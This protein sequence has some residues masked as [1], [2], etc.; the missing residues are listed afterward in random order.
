MVANARNASR[1]DKMDPKQEAVCSVSE[2]QE[3]RCT[4][5]TTL[6]ECFDNFC[7]YKLCTMQVILA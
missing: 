6:D 3:R 7:V 5:G 4:P 2:K 1:N